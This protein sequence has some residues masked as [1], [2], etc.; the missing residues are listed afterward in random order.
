MPWNDSQT[1]YFHIS[2]WSY[3]NIYVGLIFYILQYFDHTDLY[4]D[5]TNRKAAETGA[6]LLVKVQRFNGSLITWQRLPYCCRQ[7]GLHHKS[8]LSFVYFGCFYGL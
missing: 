3:G 1:N 6:E 2:D 5:H 4:K 8:E 7:K